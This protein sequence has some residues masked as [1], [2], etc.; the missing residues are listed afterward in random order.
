MRT[1][2]SRGNPIRSKQRETYTR[3]DRH[4]QVHNAPQAVR[5]PTVSQQGASVPRRGGA[6]LLLVT[7][8]RETRDNHILPAGWPPTRRRQTRLQYHYS[9]WLLWLLPAR[10]HMHSRT[11]DALLLLY[12]PPTVTVHD[13]RH[14]A[15]N[16][17]VL[18]ELR[19]RSLLPPAPA[20]LSLFPAPRAPAARREETLRRRQAASKHPPATEGSAPGGGAGGGFLLLWRQSYDYVQQYYA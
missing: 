20:P 14:V 13:K 7:T 15:R 9:C 2:G 11:G 4:S 5:T 17:K 3:R 8:G 16:A 1:G 10:I 18:L 19:G 12:S 6:P